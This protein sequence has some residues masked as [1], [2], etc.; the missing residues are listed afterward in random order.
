MTTVVVP[1]RSTDPKQRLEIDD[2]DPRRPPEAMLTDVLVGARAVARDGTTNALALA[3][4]RLFAP[5]YGPGSAGRYASLAPSRLVDAPNLVDDV[6]TVEDL[7]RVA[8]RVGPATRR[9]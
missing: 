8:R 2:A 4:D 1:F 5:L 9:L 7:V 3:D 6:D